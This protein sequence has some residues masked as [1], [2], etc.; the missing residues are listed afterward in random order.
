M[1]HRI[2]YKEYS[3]SIEVDMCIDTCTLYIDP[4][5]LKHGTLEFNLLLSQFYFLDCFDVMS[6]PEHCECVLLLQ[7]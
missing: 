1:T 7:L 3:M 2:L 4:S 5:L 6:C